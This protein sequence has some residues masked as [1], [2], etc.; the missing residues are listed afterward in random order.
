MSWGFQAL[1]FGEGLASCMGFGAMSRVWAFAVSGLA[2]PRV[3]RAQ[4][5]EWPGTSG[6]TLVEVWGMG[7]QAVG[8]LQ[9]LPL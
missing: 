5:L 4:G 8:N 9:R 7:N 6:F 3:Y 2:C 1:S